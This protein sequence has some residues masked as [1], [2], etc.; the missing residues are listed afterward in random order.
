M[1]IAAE[2]SVT[3]AAITGNY[4]GTIAIEDKTPPH[5]YRLIVQ[6]S[7]RTGFVKGQAA[8]ALVPEENRTRVNVTATADVGGAVARVGQRLVEG[9]ARMMMDRFYACLAG[10]LTG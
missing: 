10:R 6:G 3:V 5:S 7:G 8:I 4:G 1:R 9:V 2:L